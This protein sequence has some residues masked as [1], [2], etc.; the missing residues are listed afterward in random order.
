MK[1]NFL[2]TRGYIETR[3]E[4][5]RMHSALLLGYK[6]RQ[7][8]IDCGEDWLHEIHRLQPRPDAILVTHAHPDHAGGLRNGAP[9]PVF[10]TVEAW[11][12]MAKH[13][14]VERRAIL[15]RHQF[16]IGSFII[17]AFPVVHSVRA[18]A[19]G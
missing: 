6:G 13:A 18:P 12:E 15:P 8:L 7:L 16:R 19:V 4:R 9:C 3:T 11:Q 5:H 14:I 10:A 2:G 1:L 17:E